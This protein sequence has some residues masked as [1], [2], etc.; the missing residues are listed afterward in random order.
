MTTAPIAGLRD[1]N[2][3]HA[4]DLRGDIAALR[5]PLLLLMAGASGSIVP[6]HVMDEIR[7]HH[8]PGVRIVTFEEQGHNLHR[9]DFEGFCD[10]V[11]DFLAE[12]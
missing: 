1:E 3:S 6:T 11:D 7:A 9:T 5:K 2:P 8:G 10:E 4:W 12:R